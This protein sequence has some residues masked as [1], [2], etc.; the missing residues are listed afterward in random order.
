MATLADRVLDG[1]LTILDT[2]AT[3]LDICSTEPTTYAQA[4]STYSLGNK[5]GISI[6]APADRSGG[7]REVTL[8]AITDGTVTANGNAAFYAIT[9]ATNSRLLATGAITT[10][11]NV[12]SGNPFTLASL[13]IGIPD[14]A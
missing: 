8:A 9:D 5:T 14:P 3:R 7:G 2:E 13:K 12:V 6:G 1:A 10:P 4:T 11:Q